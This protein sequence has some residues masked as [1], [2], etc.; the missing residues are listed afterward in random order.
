MPDV[1]RKRRLIQDEDEDEV[2]E[3]E[4]R[5]SRSLK[6]KGKDVKGKVTNPSPPKNKMDEHSH[7]KVEPLIH[8][9]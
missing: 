3:Q 8:S 7:V 1:T 6:D 9:I 5:S 2:E 4:V